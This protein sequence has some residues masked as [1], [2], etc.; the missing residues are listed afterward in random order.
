MQVP[1]YDRQ[2]NIDAG[3]VVTPQAPG[4]VREAFGEGVYKARQGVGQ[5]VQ[6]VGGALKVVADRQAKT[7]NEAALAQYDTEYRQAMQDRLFNS[8]QEEYTNNGVKAERAKGILNRQLDSA[9]GSTQEFDAWHQGQKAQLLS[10][11]SDPRYRQKLS[12]D[13]DNF[14]LQMRDNVISH[15]ASQK[16]NASVVRMESSITQQ[17]QDAVMSKTPEDLQRAIDQVSETQQGL[18]QINGYDPKTAALNTNNAV[19]KLVETAVIG[20]IEL[21]KTG[22]T[23][24]M[25]L[26]GASDK[27]QPKEKALLNKKIDNQMKVIS[28][29]KEDDLYSRFLDETLTMGDVLSS[30]TPELEGGIGPKKA[31]G[32]KTKLI[33]AQKTEL[34][35]IASNDGAAEDYVNLV[36]K[37]ITNDVD[38]YNAKQ[39]LVDAKA[40]GIIDK[41]EAARL[42]QIKK[43]LTDMKWNANSGFF[44]SAVRGVKGWFGAHNPDNKQLGVALKKLITNTDPANLSEEGVLLNKDKIITD[45]KNKMHPER[46]VYKQGEII[47]NP[48]GVS[49]IVDGEFPDGRPRLKR[50]SK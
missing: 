33:K 37:M 34:K 32:L 46:S 23:S 24:R 20:N 36:G 25:L 15:E 3:N 31:E 10:K 26:E 42:K 6:D 44:E 4:V 14:G 22:A 12:E 30:A 48:Y 27:I 13:I 40:D 9:T 21:D 39:V 5:A 38:N 28:K 8:E 29:E 1:T 41:D 17:T 18:N 50:V 35:D 19:G 45:Q 49:F 43:V 16:H 11:I 7:Q 47:T 2:V